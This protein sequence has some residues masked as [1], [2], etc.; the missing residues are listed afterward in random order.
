M[1]AVRNWQW[2]KIFTGAFLGFLVLA[3]LTAKD[4]W[5]GTGSVAQA[6]QCFTEDAEWHLQ[7]GDV[8]VQYGRSH[9]GA[10][11]CIQNGKIDSAAAFLNGGVEGAGSTAGYVWESQGAWIE[12]Q[13]D[14]WVEFRAR[15]K[16]KLCVAGKYTPICSL[17]E[18][19]TYIGKYS[20]IA[21]PHTRDRMPGIHATVEW[22]SATGCH[23]EA[24]RERVR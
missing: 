21:G 13:S 17:T 10:T 5:T 12:S 22:C 24:L 14:T 19:Q 15:A 23:E 11:I 2:R 4:T 6:G 1:K 8:G 18:T 9:F 3:S 20:S 7:S 16:M